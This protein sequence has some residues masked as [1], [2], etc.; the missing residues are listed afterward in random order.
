MTE[1]EK[2]KEF[3]RVIIREYCWNFGEPDGCTIQDL[4]ENLGLIE[5][6]IA[7]EKDVDAESDDYEV[8]DTIFKFT[9]ILKDKDN[10]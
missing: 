8:G 6:H 2:L 4:A 10:E 5:P 3:A 7:T 9:D 1:T